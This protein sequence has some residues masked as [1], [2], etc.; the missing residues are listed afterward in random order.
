MGF[1]DRFKVHTTSEY[2]EG[3]ERV[4]R[5]HQEA[6]NLSYVEGIYKENGCFQMSVS[7]V[8]GVHKEGEEAE[9]YDCSGLP[10]AAVRIKEVRIGSGED[11]SKTSEAGEEGIIVFDLVRGEDSWQERGQY[12]MTYSA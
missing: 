5:L 1:L 2:E 6:G 4:Y 7:F 11:R 9:I 3:K 10:A 12:L 8:K